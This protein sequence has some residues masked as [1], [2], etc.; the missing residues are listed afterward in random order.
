MLPLPPVW[1]SLALA[2]APVRAPVMSRAIAAAAARPAA[3][4]TLF[5]AAAQ[6]LEQGRPWEASRLIAP[7]LADSTRRTPEALMLAATA[8]S[9]WNGWR[10]VVRLLDRQPWV[11]SVPDGR[12]RLLL[13]RGS[14]ETGADS[15][16][17]R[18]ALAVPPSNVAALD[19]TRL[20]TLA[21]A[22]ERLGARDSAGRTYARAADE[23]PAVAGWLRV[24]AAAVT[25]DSLA[26]ARLYDG[27]T[28]PLTRDR[29]GWSEAALTRSH[30]ATAGSSS[31]ALA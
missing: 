21:L 6:A 23:L 15:A 17:L 12:A 8:A 5:S 13:A 9:R 22:L 31:A 27:I 1:I 24:R 16:A 14:F 29:I 11:D 30:P 19:G 3:V 4:D 20:V 10:E 18:H 25:D 7:V 2:I 28:D 26:R